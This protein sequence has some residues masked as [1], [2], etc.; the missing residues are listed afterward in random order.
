[1]KHGILNHIE[2]FYD[3][4]YKPVSSGIMA[5][6]GVEGGARKHED[7]PCLRNRT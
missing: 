2:K 4:A 5:G 7:H 3:S 1:M 6:G